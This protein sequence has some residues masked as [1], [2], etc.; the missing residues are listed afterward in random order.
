[1]ERGDRWRK[2]LRGWG[3]IHVGLGDGEAEGYYSVW[4]LEDQLG[5]DVAGGIQLLIRNWKAS[6]TVR[7]LEGVLASLRPP[8]VV[9]R[10][11]PRRLDER[12]YRKS[13]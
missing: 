2:H 6:S 9:R 7:A 12:V 3:S 1:M 11:S 10:T 4:M 8:S 13:I 5:E